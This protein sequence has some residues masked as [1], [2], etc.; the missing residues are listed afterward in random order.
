[1]N[2]CRFT[3]EG[4]GLLGATPGDRFVLVVPIGASP[5]SQDLRAIG[6]GL[7]SKWQLP[8][9]RWLPCGWRFPSVNCS[10]MESTSLSA[11]KPRAVVEDAGTVD[12]TCEGASSIRVDAALAGL[13]VE[14]EPGRLDEHRQRTGIHRLLF[15][16]ELGPVRTATLVQVFCSCWQDPLAALAPDASPVRLQE[17]RV[18]IPDRPVDGILEA[19]MLLI[20]QAVRLDLRCTQPGRGRHSVEGTWHDPSRHPG[21]ARRVGPMLRGTGYSARCLSPGIGGTGWVFN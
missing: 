14:L 19:L 9:H 5:V 16:E 2:H 13:G 12:N 15:I 20:V 11:L 21:P 18:D 10:E 17:C 1:M 3:H 6:T 7:C 4:L 8:T